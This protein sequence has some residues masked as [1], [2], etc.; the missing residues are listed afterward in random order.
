MIF[1][2]VPYSNEILQSVITLVWMLYKFYIL[3]S[4]IQK[5][6]FPS[7]PPLAFNLASAKIL[8][9]TQSGNPSYNHAGVFKNPG[10]RKK[11][12]SATRHYPHWLSLML[13]AGWL[14]I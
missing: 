10:K 12:Q 13:V 1:F 14:L 8:W 7:I 2:S 4:H 9:G 3:S 6:K 11:S 5:E